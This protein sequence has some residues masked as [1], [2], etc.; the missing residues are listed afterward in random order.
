MVQPWYVAGMELKKRTI[1]YR[2]SDPTWEA[3]ATHAQNAGLSI[4]EAHRIL[5]REVVAGTISLTGP[6]AYP[7]PSPY[8]PIKTSTLTYQAPTGPAKRLCRIWSA[9]TPTGNKWIA[10]V[11]ER[12]Q[13]DGMSIVN[14]AKQVRAALTAI[15]GDD[16]LRIFEWWYPGTAEEHLDEQHEVDGVISWSPVPKNLWQHGLPELTAWNP[17]ATRKDND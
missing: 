17:Y 5:I 4:P 13:E 9:P 1:H 16:E 3:F 15:Y 7:A 12:A 2:E 10:V 6:R 14:A 8:R 11:V